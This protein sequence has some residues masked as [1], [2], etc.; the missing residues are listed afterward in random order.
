MI[1]R[2]KAASRWA[3]VAA[4]QEQTFEPDYTSQAEFAKW[5]TLWRYSHGYLSFEGCASA[6]RYH[7]EWRSA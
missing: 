1:G 3:T 7:P 6:F 5:L 2:E 4:S